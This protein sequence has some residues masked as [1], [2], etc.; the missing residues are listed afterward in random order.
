MAMLVYLYCIRS[1]I[2]QPPIRFKSG[3]LYDREAK[4]TPNIYPSSDKRSAN[5][6]TND[7][8]ATVAGVVVDRIVEA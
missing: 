4:G 8:D 7:W 2:R 5:A 3:D 1:I 6:L